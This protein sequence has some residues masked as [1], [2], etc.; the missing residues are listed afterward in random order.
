MARRKRKKKSAFTADLE[1]I[2]KSE[3]ARFLDRG[4]SKKIIGR[5]NILG[6][7]LM[8]RSLCGLPIY[9]HL[10]IME[11]QRL[12]QL[13]RSSVFYLFS[14]NLR[15]FQINFALIKYGEFTGVRLIQGFTYPQIQEV[16]EATQPLNHLYRGLNPGG[17]FR[18]S[19]Y[20]YLEKRG[21]SKISTPE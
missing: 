5:K 3:L 8:E 21:K 15:E 4:S 7:D 13:T 1:K 6:D 20:D 14:S 10:Q 11:G 9:E 2:E 16:S 19:L 18:I 17:T 12:L